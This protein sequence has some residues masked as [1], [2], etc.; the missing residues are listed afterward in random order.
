MIAIIDYGMGNITSVAN[1]FEAIG[2][3]VTIANNPSQ[4]A[5]ADGFVLPGVGAFGDGMNMLHKRGFIPALEREV[6][7]F[8]KPLLGICLGLQI[9]ATMGDEH[10]HHAG[11]GWIPGK[12]TRIAL[13]HDQTALRLPH[14]GW[15]EVHR[16]IDSPLYSGL[17]PSLAF[18][19]VHSYVFVPDERLLVTGLFNYGDHHVASI[20]SNNIYATQFHPE[21]SHKSGLALLRNFS[22]IAHHA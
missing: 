21:K 19:F 18:Y 20:Q 11:L 4:L 17:A 13:P 12:V 2:T 8:G 1:A 3:P 7:S 14:I 16:P 5:A 15:N 9:L 10:G 6:F 22:A